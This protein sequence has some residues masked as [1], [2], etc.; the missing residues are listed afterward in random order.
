[1]IL[2]FVVM[3]S[4]FIDAYIC[5]FDNPPESISQMQMLSYI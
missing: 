4:L 1:M 5:M 2:S 3:V